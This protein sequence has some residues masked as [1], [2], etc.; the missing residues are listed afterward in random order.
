MGRLSFIL[1]LLLGFS[2]YSEGFFLSDGLGSRLEPLEKVTGEEEWYLKTEEDLQRSVR[3]LFHSGKE[4]KRWEEQISGDADG[5]LLET[6]YYKGV[7]REVNEYDQNDTVLSEQMYD[8][9]ANLLEHRIFNYNGEGILTGMLLLNKDGLEETHFDFLYRDNGSLRELKGGNTRILWRSSNYD[10]AFIDQVQLD[11]GAE[12][13]RYNYEKGKISLRSVYSEGDE[14][15]KTLFV[16]GENG[17][18]SNETTW[19]YPDSSLKISYF[20]ELGQAVLENLF[21]Q[22]ILRQSISRE[23]QGDR[24]LRYQER[25]GKNRFQWLYEYEDDNTDPSVS[26]YY[27]N[28]VL[29]KKVFHEEQFDR[30]VFYRNN[31]AVYEKRINREQVEGDKS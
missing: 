29:I 10:K 22:G 5:I 17:A 1:L 2:L 19:N 3:T 7:L 4:V 20:D 23:F 18:I 16:Y 14:I 31:Q 12:G 8:S 28:S 11:E 13:Y 9:E 27:R 15:E 21:I 6:Y 30:E 25:S 26:C 24:L